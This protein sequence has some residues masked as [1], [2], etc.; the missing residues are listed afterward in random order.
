[1]GFSS[2]SAALQAF[3]AA[4]QRF[5]VVLTDESMPDL[6]GTELASEIRRIRPTI[7]IIV[8]SGYGGSQLAKRAAEIGVNAV[9]RKPLYSRDLAESLA[10]VLRPLH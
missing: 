1:V 5:D 10:R 9:L 3:Q 6:S 7:A 4:P 2:S 8:M